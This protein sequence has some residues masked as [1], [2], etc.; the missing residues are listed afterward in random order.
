MVCRYSISWST[1]G[2][3][4]C[5]NGR[6]K[7]SAS[8]ESPEEVRSRLA[9]STGGSLFSNAATGQVSMSVCN[10]EGGPY[11]TGIRRMVNAAPERPGPG[12]GGGRVATT[13]GSGMNR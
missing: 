13:Y 7:P 12:F 6:R 8:L 5:G 9:V 1:Q 4:N 10:G 2:P 11:E 3:K